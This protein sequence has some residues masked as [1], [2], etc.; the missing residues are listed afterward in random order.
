MAGRER[1]RSPER[2][3]KSIG[4]ALRWYAKGF[5]FLKPDDG[6]EGLFCHYSSILDGKALK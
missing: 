3:G 6:G 4:K 1:S 5:G 2:G